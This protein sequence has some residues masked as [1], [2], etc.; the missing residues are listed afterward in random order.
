M[1]VLGEV[2]AVVPVV[3]AQAVPVHRG[4]QIAPVGD[5]DPHLGP[6]STRMVG[7]GTDRL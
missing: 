4:L 3:Q 5:V 2:G 6:S 7:P 1:G